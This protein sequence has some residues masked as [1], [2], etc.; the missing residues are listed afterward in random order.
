MH[1]SP[2]SKLGYLSFNVYGGQLELFVF[3]TGIYVPLSTLL[4]IVAEKY[5]TVTL[6]CKR[7]QLAATDHYL[8][9][10]SL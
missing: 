1:L 8:W 6:N 7:L 5:R 3:E 4:K 9:C 2:T 10:D